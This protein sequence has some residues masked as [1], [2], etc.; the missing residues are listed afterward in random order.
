MAMVQGILLL[1]E[2]RLSSEA[3]QRQTTKIVGRGAR[4][5]I[6]SEGVHRRPA[7][8]GERRV[9]WR[10]YKVRVEE[11]NKNTHWKVAT[12]RLFLLNR[13]ENEPRKSLKI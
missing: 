13:S 4:A 10:R 1:G 7:R 6:A 11:N 12:Q 2:E 9:D 5:V 3:V 8:D